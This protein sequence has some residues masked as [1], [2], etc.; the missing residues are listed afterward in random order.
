MRAR[1]VAARR[2]SVGSWVLW[3]DWMRASP[4]IVLKRLEMARERKDW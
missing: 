1:T 2:R 3:M 4:A